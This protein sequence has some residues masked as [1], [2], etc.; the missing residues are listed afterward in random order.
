MFT[1]QIAAAMEQLV[2]AGMPREQ[3][4][5][6]QSILGDCAQ[7]LQHNGPIEMASPDPPGKDASKD[8]KYYT[9]YA[10]NVP[11]GS[12]IN[13]WGD[14]VNHGDVYN[15]DNSVTNNN[16]EITNNNTT[17]NYTGG[18]VN[19][20]NTQIVISGGGITIN[21]TDYC[22]EEKEVVT[23]VTKTDES[24]EVVTSVDLQP[25]VV[26]DVD[27]D[28]ET[29]ELTVT[30]EEQSYST[31]EITYVTDID[32]TKETVNVPAECPPP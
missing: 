3:A 29:C 14:D 18:T 25:E 16:T 4:D 9:S 1:K 22:W 2:A 5:I 21:G 19:Y 26:V 10:I 6:L 30:K 24:K 23:D 7:F 17:N 11:E 15:I 32:P 28:T 20:N 12:T 8:E 13:N 27:I 31:E